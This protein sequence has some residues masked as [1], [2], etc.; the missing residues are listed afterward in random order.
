MVHL[1]I[2]FQ[3]VHIITFIQRISGND[4]PNF[5]V[6]N[7]SLENM[8]VEEL[9]FI[10]KF[11]F[12]PE[13]V[14]QRKPL[15]ENAKRAGWVGCNILLGEIP[16]QGRIPIVENGFFWGKSRSFCIE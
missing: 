4:N 9:Y 16:I 5:L 2:E 12:V 13:I 6:M 3:T 7:Y 10:P 14:E 15:S 1:A 11:F 8:R